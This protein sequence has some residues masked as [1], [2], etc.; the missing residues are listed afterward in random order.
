MIAGGDGKGAD[1]SSLKEPVAQF[2]RA[3]IVLGR[4]GERV[5]Q[6]LG[7]AVLIERVISIEEAVQV[8]AQCAQAGDS[9]LLA[10]ACA[11]LEMFKSFEERGDVFAQSVDA[12]L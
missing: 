9:V 6:A 12:L 3:V 4:D 1:F 10:P 2:C 5:A 8:A 11:S 7:G